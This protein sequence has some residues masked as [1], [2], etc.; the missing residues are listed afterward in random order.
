MKTKKWI[1]FIRGL[2]IVAVVVEHHQGRVHESEWVQLLTLFCVTAFIFC[3]GTTQAMSIQKREKTFHGDTNGIMSY[4]FR[5]IKP[6]LYEYVIASIAYLTWGG[7][8]TGKEIDFL[9]DSLVE[10]SASG[11]LYF[12]RYYF[13]LTFISPLLYYW[14][15]RILFLTNRARYGMLALFLMGI[16]FFGYWSIGKLDGLGQSYLFVYTL[17]MAIGMWSLFFPK[18]RASWELYIMGMVGMMLTAVGLYY[19]KQFYW[20]RAFEQNY[21]YHEGID[22]FFPS[23]QLNPPNVS[24]LL[25][26]AGVIVTAYAVSRITEEWEGKGI[27]RINSGLETLGKYSLDIFIWHEL[28]RDFI[29]RANVL[30]YPLM[31]RAA[32]FY[33]CEFTIPILL[34]KMYTKEKNNMYIWLGKEKKGEEIHE[35]TDDKPMA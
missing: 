12:L 28:I 24:M 27:L 9:W 6:V 8:W 30:E 32:V 17:G 18:K 29:V 15:K 11:P 10:F 35:R 1:Y 31:L 14:L 16:W 26:S 4:L 34:R 2:A 13:I 20:A 3:A 23:L 5:K 22:R 21:F 25:Y 19:T 33:G 7:A